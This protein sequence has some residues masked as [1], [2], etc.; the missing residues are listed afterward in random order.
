V[1][2]GPFTPRDLGIYRIVYSVLALIAA[3]GIARLAAFPEFMFHPPVGPLQLF[4]TFPP[5]PVL[6]GLEV[7][8]TG[9]L[10]LVGL[11]CWTRFVSI[12]AAVVLIVTYGLTY[13]LGKIDHTI[14]IVIPPLILAFA[15]WGDCLSV[16]AIR[17]RTTR[18]QSQWPLR[19]L[20][21][22]IGLPFFGAAVVKLLTGWL[23]WSSQAAHTYFITAFL[24]SD[25]ISWLAP[26]AAQFDAPAAW[27]LLD[28]LT[29]TIEFAVLATLPWWRAFRT[30]LAFA[31]LFH[32]GVLLVMNIVF[33]A[34]IVAYGAFVSWGRFIPPRRTL[35]IV[36]IAVYGTSFVV[37]P[38]AMS[39]AITFA[40]ASMGL[41]YLLFQVWTPAKVWTKNRRLKSEQ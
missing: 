25:G 3:P 40:G 15:N 29:V 27:E 6:I 32:L 24:S 39:A 9:L 12:A 41:G 34:N 23:Q 21:L 18:P 14:L 13:S 8:R 33:V 26:M 19:L 37:P 2:E 30:A 1:Q 11:G 10:I 28:W 20:A 7:T 22:A 36:P 17:R 38:H 35:L 5:L 4:P 31:T 16:D